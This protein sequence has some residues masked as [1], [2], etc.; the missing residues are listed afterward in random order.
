MTKRQWTLF[1]TVVF[2]LAAFIFV[3][4]LP[5]FRGLHHHWIF[6]VLASLFAA[7]WA[8]ARPAGFYEAPAARSVIMSF[9]CFLMLMGIV[10]HQTILACFGHCAFKLGGA[11]ALA[12]P[13][14]ALQARL[15]DETAWRPAR[16]FAAALGCAFWSVFLVLFGLKAPRW[17]PEGLMLTGAAALLPF[18]GKPQVKALLYAMVPAL[19]LARFAGEYATI[20]AGVPLALA[21]LWFAGRGQA[22]APER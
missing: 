3:T 15:G 19:L 10:R 7:E 4:S 13:V 14:F 2:N 20:F 6:P 22:A 11:A 17:I 21:G 9:L 12:A 5:A 1:G 8:A 16:A 18:R